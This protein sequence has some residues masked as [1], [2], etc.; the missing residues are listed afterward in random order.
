MEIE[1]I[2]YQGGPMNGLVASGSSRGKQWSSYRRDN[3]SLMP[4]GEGDR[5]FIHGGR[6]R[7]GYCLTETEN[8]RAYIHATVT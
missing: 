2:R 8:G 6:K 7:H 4:T 5:I 1:V 3:G